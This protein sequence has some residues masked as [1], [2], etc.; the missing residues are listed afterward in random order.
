M[1]F[2]SENKI[3]QEQVNSFDEEMNLELVKRLKKDNYNK[4]FDGLKDRHLLRDLAIN[5]PKLTT[6]YIH[7]YNQESFD[8]N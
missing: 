7:L 3:S 6:N 4:L 5:R 2:I 8:E 1:K